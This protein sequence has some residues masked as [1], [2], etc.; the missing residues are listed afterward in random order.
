MTMRHVES[1]PI[2]HRR[3]RAIGLLLAA[4][5]LMAADWPTYMHDIARSGVTD[6]SLTVQNLQERWV[7]T[8]PAPPRVAWDGGAPWDAWR[9]GGAGSPFEL[10]P[11]RDFDFVFHV[12][13]SGGRL[14]FG[15][16]TTDSV[17]CLDVPTGVEQW[18]YVTD[19]PVRYPPTVSDGKLYFGSDDGHAYCIDALDASF[20]WKYSP[21][22]ATRLVGNNGSLIP[23]WPVRTGTAVLDGSVYFAASLV[24]WEDS[25]LCAV[26]ALTGSDQGTGRYK[27]SGGVTPMGAIMV[28]PSRIYLTQGRLH[29][30]VFDRAD[31][32]LLDT[33]GS[34]GHGGC[35][36]LL[37]DDDAF[38]H[39]HSRANTAGREVREYDASTVDLLATHANARRLVV[40]GGTSYVLTETTLAAIDRSDQSLVWFVSCDC[41]HA[42]VL[43]GGVLFAGGRNVVRAY[44]A[45]D[46]S[47]LWSS[48]VQGRAR[49]LAVAEG[50]LFVST[51]TGAIHAFS[52]PGP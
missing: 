10:V 14:Y 31:G 34:W 50:C 15:S 24:S 40:S 20:V 18:Y 33:A 36:A 22:D 48:P 42:L 2:T 38:V 51:D 25:Y 29:P 45:T 32:S 47:L 19:G 7:H 17:H 35:F 27:V 44:D 16:S 3:T 8:S 26:D 30:H 4:P 12:S 37:T 41:P 11:M 9:S 5:L 21:S 52:D 39:G 46:G 23:L 43:A 13:A 49:G 1:K 6:E 28:S